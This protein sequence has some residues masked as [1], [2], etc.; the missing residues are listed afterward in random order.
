MQP[1]HK[2]AIIIFQLLIL[3][4]CIVGIVMTILSQ[5]GPVPSLRD[6]M[7]YVGYGM[8]LFYA[9]VGYRFPHGNLFKY[10][11]LAFAALLVVTLLLNPF[12]AG[13]A[14][15]ETVRLNLMEMGFL[16]A[17]LVLVSYMAGRLNRLKENEIIVGAVFLL[18]LARAIL[19]KY[20]P[21]KI[22]VGFNEFNMWIVLA[23]SYLFHYHAHR[24]AGL[25][26]DHW[27]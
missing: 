20:E 18:F 16:G 26:A 5:G 10:T 9:L 14:G 3:A 19:V 27:H 15:E 11:L 13:S 12:L 7:V 17:I 2:P 4:L 24:D 22:S 1:K 6:V 8:V 21:G 23:C 25:E